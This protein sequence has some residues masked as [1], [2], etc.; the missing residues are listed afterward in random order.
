[1][2]VPFLILYYNIYVLIAVILGYSSY[3]GD[4]LSKVKI[5]FI[6]L[7]YF[8]NIFTRTKVLY[9]SLFTI[10]LNSYYFLL[11]FISYF[12]L[13]IFLISLRSSLYFYYNRAT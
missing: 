2:S 13:Y 10:L 9:I 7:S 4:F 12:N 8:S 1:M 6:K 11:S 3:L 5:M